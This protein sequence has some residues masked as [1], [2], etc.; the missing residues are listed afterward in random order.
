M[1]SRTWRNLCKNRVRRLF[2]SS[3][4]NVFKS[5]S[6]WL[7]NLFF[8]SATNGNTTSNSYEKTH[9]KYSRLA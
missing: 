4:V 6:D 7:C 9:A 1:T 8:F 2:I 3:A 5:T